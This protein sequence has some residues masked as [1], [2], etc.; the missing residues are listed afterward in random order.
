[1][2]EDDGVIGAADD[3]EEDHQV[4]RYSLTSY[5]TY[6]FMY[7]MKSFIICIIYS[8]SFIR[9]SPPA[10]N[11]SSNSGPQVDELQCTS[12]ICGNQLCP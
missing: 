6:E 12:C 4:A 10:P 9:H 11:N 1:M 5:K 8:M 7:Y 3:A 2:G